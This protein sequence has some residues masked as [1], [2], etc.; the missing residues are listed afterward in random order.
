MNLVNPFSTALTITKVTSTVS[1]SGIILGTIDAD[2][3]FSNPAKS[4]T[5][6]P[7]LDLSMNFDPS[8]LFSVTR[9]LAVKA[10][11]DVEPLD[12]IVKLGDIQY[13]SAVGDTSSSSRRDN[14]FT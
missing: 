2:T 1:S 8:A 14:I 10:G 4:T 5:T 9:I 12:Q 3:K 13:L 6:S 7:N 11:L